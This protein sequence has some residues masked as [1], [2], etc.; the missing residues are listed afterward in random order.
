MSKAAKPAGAA[1]AHFQKS[2]DGDV[3]HFLS[4]TL[5]AHTLDDEPRHVL[6]KLQNLKDALAQQEKTLSTWPD[7]PNKERICAALAQAKRQIAQ[8]VDDFQK[9]GDATIADAKAS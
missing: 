8:T 7:S 1:P 9:A 5:Q 6:A 2:N 4:R 3:L